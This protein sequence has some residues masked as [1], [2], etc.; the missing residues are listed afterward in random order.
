[1]KI[2]YEENVRNIGSCLLKKTSSYDSRWEM[3]KANWKWNKA[4][5]DQALQTK[6]LGIRYYKK[7]RA[8]F[9]RDKDLTLQYITQKN[10]L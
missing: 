10:A 2:L 8:K 9:E 4:A 3:W 1:M 6:Y 7:P 5:H